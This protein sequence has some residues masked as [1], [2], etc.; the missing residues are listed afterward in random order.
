MTVGELKELLGN[1]SPSLVV[2]NAAMQD[3]TSVGFEI[4]KA[5]NDLTPDEL[6]VVIT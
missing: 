6:V 3:I 2:C 5:A 1:F 4:Q